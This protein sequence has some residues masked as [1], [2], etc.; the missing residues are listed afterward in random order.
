MK[1]GVK[2]SDPMSPLLFDSLI[3]ALEDRGSGLGW[4]GQLITMLAFADELMLL[5]LC[6]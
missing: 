6:C 4:E 1:V 2:Q 5:S 3:Q